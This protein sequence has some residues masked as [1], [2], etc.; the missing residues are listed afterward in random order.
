[1]S[2]IAVSVLLPCIGL[3]FGLDPHLA[4]AWTYALFAAFVFAT[5]ASAITAPAGQQQIAR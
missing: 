4:S 2:V 5:G 3:G 1:M